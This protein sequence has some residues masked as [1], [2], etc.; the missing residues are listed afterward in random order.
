MTSL[1]E[2]RFIAMKTMTLICP[3][4][5]QGAALVAQWDVECR[6]ILRYLEAQN[7]PKIQSVSQFAHCMTEPWVIMSIHVPLSNLFYDFYFLYFIF[8]FH[9]SIQTESSFVA[10]IFQNLVKLTIICFW[11]VEWL[12]CQTTVISS[13]QLFNFKFCSL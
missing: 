12:G 9:C 5:Q 2:K 3:V 8:I 10:F 1:R 7:V 6:V 4:L 11:S 13:Y